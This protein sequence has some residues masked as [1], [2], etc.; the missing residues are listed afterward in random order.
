MTDLRDIKGHEAAKRGIEI[1]VTGRHSI[2]LHGPMGC[3]KTMLLRAAEELG[4]GRVTALDD[5]DRADA[6]WVSATIDEGTLVVAIATEIAGLAARLL[7]RFPIIVC[8]PR[9]SAAE[10]LA[11]S[12]A[13]NSQQVAER[14]AASEAR[15]EPSLEL[16]QGTVKLMREFA[17]AERITIR[18]WYSTLA[19]ARTIARM[20]SEPRVK[21]IHAAEACSYAPRANRMPEARG[22]AA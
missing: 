12:P 21:R 14:I 17:D 15:P 19:V 6:Q 8:L 10:L 18:V 1:A 7:D 13:E 3:G 16:D 22:E 9:V 2:L 4:R 5:I 11:P 20:E